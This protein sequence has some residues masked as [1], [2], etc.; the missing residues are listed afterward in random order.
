MHQH[1]LFREAEGI[2]PMKPR[3]RVLH[4]AEYCATS[5][6]PYGLGR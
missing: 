6:K 3:Q 5:N 2:G 4:T 1:F